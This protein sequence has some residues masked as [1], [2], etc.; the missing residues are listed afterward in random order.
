MWRIFLRSV[1]FATDDVDVDSSV[2]VFGRM[3]LKRRFEYRG[4]GYEYWTVTQRLV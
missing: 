2:P 4:L 3:A 1:F